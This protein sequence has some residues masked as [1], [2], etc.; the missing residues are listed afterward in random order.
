MP[1]RRQ[2]SAK[3]N[4]RDSTRSNLDDEELF[5]AIQYGVNGCM[6]NRIPPSR[7]FELLQGVR[8]GEVA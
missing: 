3:G 2:T 7:F 6:L 4:T 1:V 5:A 8:Q